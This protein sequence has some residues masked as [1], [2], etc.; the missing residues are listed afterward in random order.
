M[1]V[2]VECPPGTSVT[3]RKLAL[4]ATSG[5][6]HPTSAK[7][8]TPQSGQQVWEARDRTMNA[9]Q[10]AV[11]FLLFPRQ[12]DDRLAAIVADSQR[13]RSHAVVEA[14]QAEIA[15]VEIEAAILSNLEPSDARP[16][17][18]VLT[19]LTCSLEHVRGDR[20]TERRERDTDILGLE[21]DTITIGR[22]DVAATNSEP[23]TELPLK[24]QVEVI[25]LK[26]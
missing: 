15:N 1:S 19:T 16:R 25:N 8:I 17:S 18:L 2:I 26:L 9:F 20:L 7:S 13:E 4:M 21:I 10:S 6:A 22:Q 3:L 11:V 23:I 24:L 5:T 12:G 14:H